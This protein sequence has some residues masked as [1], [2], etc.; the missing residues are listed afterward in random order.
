MELSI[1][2]EGG[3][4]ADLLWPDYG[5]EQIQQMIEQRHITRSWLERIQRA[6]GWLLFLRLSITRTYHDI[7]SRPLHEITALQSENAT[8]ADYKWSD[9]AVYVELLQ[10]LLFAR[11]VGTLR[12]IIKPRLQVL[13]SCWDE[14]PGTNGVAPGELLRRYMPMLA[15]FIDATW[16]ANAV[17]IIGLS[18]L[19]KTLSPDKSDEEYLDEGP[20]SFGFVVLPDGSRQPDLTLPIELLLRSAT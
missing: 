19:G 6:E 11:K 10:L 1:G 4:Q 5:G 17:Q 2:S 15:D 9:Q 14:L 16:S 18:S 7:I 3:M 13:L 20:Q 12:P 8:S